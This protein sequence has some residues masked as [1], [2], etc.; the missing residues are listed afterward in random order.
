[1]E[2]YVD[3]FNMQA[4][5]EKDILMINPQSLAFVGDAVYSLFIRTHFCMVSNA[6]SRS[7]HKFSTDFVKASAQSKALDDIYDSLSEDEMAVA[8]R[9]RNTKVNTMSKNAKMIEYKKSTAFEALL[10]YLYLLGKN[11]RL[12]YILNLSVKNFGEN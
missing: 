5:S 3:I 8:K 11:E 6:R 9:A 12:N 2:N 1:M 7:L 10:G 4:K